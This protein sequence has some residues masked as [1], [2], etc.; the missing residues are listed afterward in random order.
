MFLSDLK[1]FVDFCALLFPRNQKDW[2]RLPLMPSF[3]V[4]LPYMISYSAGEKQVELLLV[5]NGHFPS[6][7]EVECLQ[8]ASFTTNLQLLHVGR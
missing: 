2:R 1:L 4:P 6:P 3:Q 8:E 5:L 7:F